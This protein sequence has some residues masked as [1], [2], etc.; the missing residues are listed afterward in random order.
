MTSERFIDG[1]AGRLFVDDGGPASA[2]ARRP[3][4][5]RDAALASIGP[6]LR[7]DFLKMLEGGRP[8]T[9]ARVLADFDR[10]P[11]ELSC[12]WVRSGWTTDPVPQLERYLSRG[13]R[14]HALHADWRCRNPWR[15][16]AQL[17][18]V[19]EERVPGTSHWVMMDE[20]DELQPRLDRFLRSL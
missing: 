11:L 13:G 16:H 17:P 7:D 5:E 2:L 18:A 12:D 20:P 10:T 14:A 8:A 6:G 3:Q 9:R 15:P 19:T 4:A 1:P